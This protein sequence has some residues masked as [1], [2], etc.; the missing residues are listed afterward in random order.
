[1][2]FSEI[3]YTRPDYPAISQELAAL[4]QKLEGAASAREQADLY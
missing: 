2:K 4:T 1:M 3:T